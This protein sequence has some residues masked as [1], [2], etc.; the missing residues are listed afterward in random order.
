[1]TCETSGTVC[2][3]SHLTPGSAWTEATGAHPVVV[4]WPSSGPEAR[5]AVQPWAA[6]SSTLRAKLGAGAAAV[7]FR[8]SAS[9]AKASL[10]KRCVCTWLLT[11]AVT[12]TGRKLVKRRAKADGSRPREA[13]GVAALGMTPARR[14]AAQRHSA[15][16]RP[17][18]CQCLRPRCG[19]SL[20][21]SGR[22]NSGTEPESP[23]GGV[24]S[25]HSAA[26][27]T[28]RLRCVRPALVTGKRFLAQSSA[29]VPPPCWRHGRVRG[30]T[31]FSE[32]LGV[33][34]CPPTRL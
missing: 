7:H 8:F 11:R 31:D 14:P 28:E 17:E 29:R 5:P 16:P 24:Q 4:A 12:R 19:T 20:T 32:A 33:A 30:G 27:F 3:P 2:R 9:S 18:Q 34:V 26:P 15:A 1:M 23:P 25:G 13:R 10:T 21:T 6:S 22:K